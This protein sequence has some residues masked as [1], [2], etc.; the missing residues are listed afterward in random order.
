[1]VEVEIETLRQELKKKEKM[2]RRRI[3]EDSK[4]NGGCGCSDLREEGGRVG[5]A[6]EEEREGLRY[7]R[8]QNG[9]VG[10]ERKSGVL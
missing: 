3:L 8:A 9:A 1:M 7:H 4:Q 10:K 6:S 2:V 5:K